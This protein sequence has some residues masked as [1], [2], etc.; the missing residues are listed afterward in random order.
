[1]SN[2][3]TKWILELVDKITS[4][5]KEVFSNTLKT[6]KGIEALDES[7][8]DLGYTAVNI[9]AIADSFRALNDRLNSAIELGIIKF[10]DELADV[11]A[12]MGVADETLEPLS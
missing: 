4:P 12:I 11:Q 3:S 1:M 8:D 6:K 2:V 5:M 9:N 10:Q 7:I